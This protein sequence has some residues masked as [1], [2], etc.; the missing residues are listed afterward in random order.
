M[1]PKYVTITSPRRPIDIYLVNCHRNFSTENSVRTLKSP[2]N[3]EMVIL[4]RATYKGNSLST[5]PVLTCAHSV[6]NTIV[7]LNH[8]LNGT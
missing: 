5:A 1:V 8:S 4:P 3:H 2:F 6:E 7:T